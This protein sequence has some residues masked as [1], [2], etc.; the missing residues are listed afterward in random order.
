MNNNP[1][2]IP[3]ILNKIKR[4]WETD[5]NITLC[6]I[7]TILQR[8]FLDNKKDTQPPPPM[9]F[10]FTDY[11]LEYEIDKIFEED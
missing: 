8:R 11:D 5:P 2:R 9:L 7:L 1:Q 4:L 6:Q 10:Y 3:R